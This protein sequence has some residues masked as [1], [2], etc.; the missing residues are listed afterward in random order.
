[1]KT[2]NSNLHSAKKAKN[3]E[4][5]TQLSDIEFEL[6]HYKQH[7]KGKVVY[8]NCDDPEWSNFFK[9]FAMQFNH[10]G[11]KKLISTCYNE[12]GN[13]YKLIIEKDINN[14]GRINI[15]DTEKELLNGDGS[16]DSDECIELLKE[17]DIVVSNPPFSLFREYIAML[18]KYN[19]QFLV[20]GN[21]NA[22]T[23]KECFKL[24]KENKM[25][26]GYTSP[27]EFRQPDGAI[28]KTM[29][30]LCKW[31]TNLSHK[32]RNEEIYLYE[33][34]SPEKYPKYD[35]Y[36]AINVD[37]TKEIPKDW[38]GVMGVPITFLDKWNPEQFEIVSCNDYRVNDKLTFKESGLVKDKDS[39]I[40]GKAK[41]VRILIRN[42]QL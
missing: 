19:K 29:T 30:G 41:S 9:Y 38:K 7:F 33:E 42:K 28:L 5:Y 22:I 16:F 13:G 12:N 2:K 4:F 17:A 31:F 40:N 27:S 39:A 26:L 15:Q 25:W 24:I 35:N 37:K 18:D 23:Y 8:C 1:M 6:K 32:K 36:D 14:D 20:I 3:D 21:K 34:Y 10:L 11:L